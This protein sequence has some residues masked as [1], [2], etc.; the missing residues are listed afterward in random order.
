MARTR[1]TS[2]GSAPST[3]SPIRRPRRRP[4][5]SR[6]NGPRCVRLRAW[7]RE[8]LAARAGRLAARRRVRARR[9]RAQLRRARRTRRTHRRHRRERGDARHRPRACCARGRR[10]DV[11]RRRRD[12]RS[13]NPTQSFDA[14][15]SERV[16]QWLPDMEAAIRGDAAGAATRWARVPDRQRL[17]DVRRRPAGSRAQRARSPTRS[18]TF[19][20][21]GAA[22]GGRLLNV[23]R[24]V[25]LT[26]LAHSASTPRLG[27]LGSR[28]STRVR[29]ACSRS[30]TSS[31][32]VVAAGH[33]DD[34]DAERFFDQHRSGRACRP[35]VHVGEHDVGVRPSLD[36][37]DDGE[38]ATSCRA[39]RPS[40]RDRCRRVRRARQRGARAARGTGSTTRSRDRPRGR[41]RPTPGRRRAHRRSRASGRVARCDR[42]R[43]RS[44]TSSPTPRTS[45]VSNGFASS[46]FSSR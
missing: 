13:T 35:P 14:C 33:L 11:P 3:T 10:R 19:R 21:D 45:S 4:W 41:R 22:T 20:G 38:A 25:G 42:A 31:E 37:R 9:G 28:S 8:H 5:R 7:E 12:S 40:C 34:A 32:L 17:A 1:S 24:D 43:P 26:D 23:C 44:R 18:W 27:R 36:R 15:R 30:A 39:V 46:S 6:R 29:L 16:L 2:A